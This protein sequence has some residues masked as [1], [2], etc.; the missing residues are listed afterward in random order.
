[1]N[2]TNKQKK[3]LNLLD[4]TDFGLLSQIKENSITVILLKLIISVAGGHCDCSPWTPK[5]PS[6]ATYWLYGWFHRLAGRS[7]YSLPSL[8]KFSKN[9]ERIYLMCP[10]EF[11]MSDKSVKT[12][13][14]VYKSRKHI[15]GEGTGCIDLFILNFGAGCEMEDGSDCYCRTDS[16]P[17][18]KFYVL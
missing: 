16:T 12:K 15:R 13:L 4:S 6:Y 9:C 1:M 10:S 14:S 2:V 3:K 5:R 8:I 11:I 17:Y 18:S 7:P